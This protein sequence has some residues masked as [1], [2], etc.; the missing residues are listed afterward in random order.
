M[1]S[2]FADMYTTELT[3][4]AT[5]CQLR[6]DIDAMRG[7][8]GS[9]CQIILCRAPFQVAAPFWTTPSHWLDDMFHRA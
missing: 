2:A 5:K 4:E 3:I 7:L 9:S 8:L 1:D 6:I